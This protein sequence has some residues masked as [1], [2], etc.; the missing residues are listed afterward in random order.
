LRANDTLT[1][2]YDVAPM[3]GAFAGLFRRRAW[4]GFWRWISIAPVSIASARRTPTFEH[5]HSVFPVR[6]DH[7]AGVIASVSS[8]PKRRF[9]VQVDTRQAHVSIEAG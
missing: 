5:D 2:T 6:P 3:E 4:H 8:L 7:D 9:P 1:P